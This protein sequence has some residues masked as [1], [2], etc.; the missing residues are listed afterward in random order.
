MTIIRNTNSELVKLSELDQMIESM[1]KTKYPNSD[2]ILG[3]MLRYSFM[4]CYGVNLNMFDTHKHIIYYPNGTICDTYYFYEAPMDKIKELVEKAKKSNTI[5]DQIDMKGCYPEGIFLGFFATE[6]KDPELRKKYQ[7]EY[8]NFLS[9]AVM[10]IRAQTISTGASVSRGLAYSYVTSLMDTIYIIK[11]SLNFD[12]DL[13]KI[14][15]ETNKFYFDI[16]REVKMR[17][18]KAAVDHKK[19]FMTAIAG[20]NYAD[21]M[22]FYRTYVDKDIEKSTESDCINEGNS[23]NNEDTDS[24]NNIIGHFTTNKETSTDEKKVK[25]FHVFQYNPFE[26]DKFKDLPICI[27]HKT[28]VER[29]FNGDTMIYTTQLD[30]ENLAD[31][32][33]YHIIYHDGY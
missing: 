7:V 21:I 25:E 22:S 26:D 30:L 33:G 32:Y 11:A 4:K 17:F 10:A 3:D 18:I 14:Q 20:Y 31:S 12:F 15:N 24:E 6:F 9:E 27:D 8:I 16:Y 5:N 1:M 13:D 2:S 29:I 19:E 23:S 28:A